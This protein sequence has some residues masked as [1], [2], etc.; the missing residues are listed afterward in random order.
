MHCRFRF[1]SR[2]DRS[3]WLTDIAAPPD[4]LGYAIRVYKLRQSRKIMEHQIDDG[5]QESLPDFTGESY[6]AILRRLHLELQPG[7]YFE[8]GTETG[9]SL[10]LARCAS[11]AVD[12]DFKLASGRPASNKPLCAL[13]QRSSDAFFASV[14]PTV[15]LGQRI[16]LAF[17]D[18]MHLCEF[19][20]RD[21]ANT[22]RFCTPNSVIALHD[23]LPLDLVMAE[24]EWP[25]AD[26]QI[27]SRKG[28][29]TGD[30][31]RCAL[32]L[33]RHR[34]NLRI[35]ALDAPPTGL[36]LVTNLDPDS[37]FIHDHY[38]SLV[39]EMHATTLSEVT[40][41]GLHAE[42]NVEPTSAL[43][44]FEQIAARFWL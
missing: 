33:K 42:L 28:W 16:D 21:F 35:T 41:A 37:T 17:L 40:L 22:E 44:R 38:A 3:C 34:L 30:V 14:D 11:L 36:V 31:W 18:G 13:Y 20:L 8:I 9:K 27:T 15:V 26:R 43:S 23:C 39:E 1:G 7:T 2:R 10:S 19:L 6:L 32:L 24:R 5:E 4:A 25:S 29:W 12:P